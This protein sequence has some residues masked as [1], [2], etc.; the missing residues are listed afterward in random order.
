MRVGAGRV[1]DGGEDSKVFR[2][3]EGFMVT[4]TGG[5][6]S[7][8]VEEIWEAAGGFGAIGVVGEIAGGKYIIFVEFFRSGGRGRVVG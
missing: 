5:R 2:V 4:G 3:S 1:A 6:R 8:L 7:C